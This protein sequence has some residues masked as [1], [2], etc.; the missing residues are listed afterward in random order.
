MTEWCEMPKI[1]S[2]RGKFCLKVYAFEGQIKPYFRDQSQRFFRKNF[3][4]R[5]MRIS[6]KNAAVS[7]VRR[8][9]HPTLQPGS[10][11]RLFLTDF[12]KKRTCRL[13][14]N[15]T[16]KIAQKMPNETQ[17]R[18]KTLKIKI[19]HPIKGR[20]IVRSIKNQNDPGSMNP[21]SLPVSVIFR[22]PN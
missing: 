19:A 6:A 22:E 13:L 18:N 5:M 20:A 12:V 4:S 21:A 8:G 7:M 14:K 11:T 17:K 15:C 3:A 16:V 10:C 2:L 9:L 1:G